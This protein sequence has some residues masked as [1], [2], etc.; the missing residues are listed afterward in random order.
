MSRIFHPLLYILVTATKQELI[1]RIHYLKSENH[2]LRNRLPKTIRTTPQERRQLVKAARGLTKETLRELVGIVA[3]ATLLGWRNRDEQPVS[4]KAA[5]SRKP[6]RPRTAEDGH[7]CAAS[8][9][10]LP[11]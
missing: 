10:V 5:S 9:A 11:G 1:R 2:V 4:G 6:G 3:P 8:S 7:H